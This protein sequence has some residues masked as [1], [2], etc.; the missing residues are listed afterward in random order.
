MRIFIM[1]LPVLAIFLVGMGLSIWIVRS[2][3]PRA[4]RLA[5][6]LGVRKV[7]EMERAIQDKA[8]R[9]AYMALL[10]GLI[11]DMYYRVFAKGEIAP[12]TGILAMAS[13]LVQSVAVL[14]LRRRSTAGDEEYTETPVWKTLAL[15]FVVAGVLTAVGCALIFSGIGR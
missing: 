14:V 3:S 4:K 2:K 1:M 9:I 10:V 12:V 6:L 5:E 8:V 11:A 15:V 7:D 13:V